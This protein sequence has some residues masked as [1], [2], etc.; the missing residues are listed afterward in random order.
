MKASAQHAGI[1]ACTLEVFN[2]SAAA[3]L[4]ISLYIILK[5]K[6]KYVTVKHAQQHSSFSRISLINAW[7]Y[8]T[9]CAH[10]AE[11]SQKSQIQVQRCSIS[12]FWT[13]IKNMNFAAQLSFLE[14]S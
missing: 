10:Q 12:I 6:R 11:S 9:E 4:V 13:L 14:T 8:T 5:C 2:A 3:G 7:K 1:K